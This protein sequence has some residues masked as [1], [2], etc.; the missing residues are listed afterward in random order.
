MPRMWPHAQPSVELSTLGKVCSAYRSS[1]SA[2][3]GAGRCSGPLQR[4]QQ[5]PR[6][7]DGRCLARCFRTDVI[8]PLL[9]KRG[10]RCVHCLL[11]ASSVAYLRELQARTTVPQDASSPQCLGPSFASGK[12]AQVRCS[13]REARVSSCLVLACTAPAVPLV[14]SQPSCADCECL[15]FY[16]G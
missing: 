13:S 3:V 9:A 5:R 8:T 11:F 15:A 12:T 16:L 4:A 1:R 10:K 14:V 7:S 2:C 6:G